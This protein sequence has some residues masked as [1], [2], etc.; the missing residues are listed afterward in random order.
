[1]ALFTLYQSTYQ[2]VSLLFL[3]CDSMFWF[4]IFSFKSFNIPLLSTSHFSFMT[5]FN[6]LSRFSS[7]KRINDWQIRR[8]MLNFLWDKYEL[9][10]SFSDLP[11]CVLLYCFKVVFEVFGFFFDFLSLLFFGLN[12]KIN[13]DFMIFGWVMVFLLVD[14]FAHIKQ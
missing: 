12:G 10:K 14:S 3:E 9:F 1:M 13:Y 6:F 4:L 11:L 8:S 7:S 2:L 5:F